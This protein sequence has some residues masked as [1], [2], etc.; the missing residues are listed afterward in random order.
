MSDVKIAYNGQGKYRDGWERTFAR[1]GQEVRHKAHN[2]DTGGSN[3]SPATRD[4]DMPMASINGCERIYMVGN[5]FSNSW[6]GWV[7]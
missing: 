4:N 1:D 2:L 3:P 5:P 7:L 6:F